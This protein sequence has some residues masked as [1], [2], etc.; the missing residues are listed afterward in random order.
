MAEGL[1]LTPTHIVL[2]FDN[3]RTEQSE[4]AQQKFGVEGNPPAIIY[5]KR[6]TGF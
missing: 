2:A 4:W 3:N 6:P 5:F 1:V